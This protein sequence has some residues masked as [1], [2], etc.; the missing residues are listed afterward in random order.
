MT[1]FLLDA[2]FFIEAYRKGF[3]MD[4]IPSFWV[5]LKEL[6]DAGKIISLDKVKDEI[7]KNEDE[8][9]FWCEANLPASFFKDSSEVLDAYKEVVQWAYSKRENPYSQSALD[10]FME[11][12]AADAWLVAYALKHKQP[13]VTNEVAAPESKKSIKIPDACR[14]FGVQT[15][16]PMEMLRA[17]GE[18]I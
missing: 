7:Y 13:L 11:A 16:Q 17:L 8:L 18:K 15:F 3:P 2:N 9:K 10:V 14:S 5:K 1:P 4:V 12:D 6:A